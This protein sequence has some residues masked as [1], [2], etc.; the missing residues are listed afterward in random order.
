L[1]FNIFLLTP[2]ANSLDFKNIL[3]SE[4]GMLKTNWKVNLRT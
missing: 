2:K 4:M 1:R 3:H